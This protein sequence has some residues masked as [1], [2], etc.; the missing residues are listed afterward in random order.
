MHRGKVLRTALSLLLMLSFGTATTLTAS[1][2][3][4]GRHR[5]QPAGATAALVDLGISVIVPSGTT[6]LVSSHLVVG[7]AGELTAVSH[8]V[9]CQLAGSST[10]TDR[11]VSGQNVERAANV[12]L[13]T[14][15]LLT[16]PATGPLTCNL[17]VILINHT[18][19]TKFG[20]ISI[21]PGTDLAATEADPSSVNVWQIGQ[22][23]VNTQYRTGPALLTPLT[24]TTS[25]QAIGDINV[26][27][28]YSAVGACLGAGSRRSA[29]YAYVGTQLVVQQLNADGAVCRTMV[30]G[31]L[32]A[33]IITTTI[34]HRKFNKTISDI[35]LDG[36]C[37]SQTFRAFVR[38]TANRGA[39]S[40]VVEP[41][42]QS[43][44]ALYLPL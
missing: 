25:I 7:G 29:T 4:A 34:H 11:I 43:V 41:N 24:G 40:I 21:L 39:N 17:Y 33:T 16:A 3:T 23:L 14:R 35:P 42:H 15:A 8:L 1:A 28:C 27:V 10:V 5:T 32:V 36:S 30:D 44:T 37:T 19:T 22:A 9:Y 6:R 20:T 38:V 2:T 12:T 31:P 26:T 13:L 18:S